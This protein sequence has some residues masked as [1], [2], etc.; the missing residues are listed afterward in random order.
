MVE[1]CRIDVLLR[2]EREEFEVEVGE[3]LSE[4]SPKVQVKSRF[5]SILVQDGVE[6]GNG[7]QGIGESRSQRRKHFTSII[8]RD[9]GIGSIVDRT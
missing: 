7:G 4:V 3:L 1:L 8:T 5:Q 9:G 6:V 2:T